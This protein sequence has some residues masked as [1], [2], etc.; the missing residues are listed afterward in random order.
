MLRLFF[1]YRPSGAIL[2]LVR[3]DLIKGYLLKPGHLLIDYRIIP[4]L[5]VHVRRIDKTR[6]FVGN[7]I[8]PDFQILFVDLFFKSAATFFF[9]I[10]PTTAV[11]Y[12]PL[13][14]VA[15]RRTWVL[16]KNACQFRIPCT[17][18]RFCENLCLF[19]KFLI[20]LLVGMKGFCR[21]PLANV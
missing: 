9:W 14:S 5:E 19:L 20:Y 16:F 6:V 21:S 3:P 10:T 7:V 1:G 15:K 2:I 17:P 13:K 11:R 18:G 12:I 4:Q 8:V